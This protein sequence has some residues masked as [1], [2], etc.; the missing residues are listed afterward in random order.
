VGAGAPPGL[1]D[2]LVAHLASS[3]PLVEVQLHAGGQ[4]HY[5]L[6]VGVE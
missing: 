2:E 1:G 6:L 4:P 5:A 3:W